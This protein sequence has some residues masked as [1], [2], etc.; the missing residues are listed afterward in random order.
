MV[1]FTLALVAAFTVQACATLN[2][3][4]EA[5]L[6]KELAETK[7]QITELHE[8]IKAQKQPEPHSGG[9][10]GGR[11]GAFTARPILEAARQ[12]FTEDRRRLAEDAG[13]VVCRC[14]YS[15]IILYVF[16]IRLQHSFGALERLCVGRGKK[17]VV[18]R[19]EGFL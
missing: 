16:I 5:E 14:G 15:I 19:W 17:K 10:E 18:G 9:G 8:L 11:G 3:N 1:R 13:S 12:D 2:P 4:V 7:A 6:R